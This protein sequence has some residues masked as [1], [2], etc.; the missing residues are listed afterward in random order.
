MG[1]DKGGGDVKVGESH[2]M[3]FISD[4]K[5]EHSGI[6]SQKPLKGGVRPAR[7]RR[8]RE[9]YWRRF[10]EKKA[11]PI[12]EKIVTENENALLRRRGL[13]ILSRSKSPYPIYWQR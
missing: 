5:S 12:L 2:W 8:T 1:E 7:R 13:I 3:P 4:L 9:D 6:S 11:F 10:E